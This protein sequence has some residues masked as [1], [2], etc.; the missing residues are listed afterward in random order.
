M[1]GRL[2]LTFYISRP[3]PSS[4]F[5]ESELDRL[6]SLLGVLRHHA[7]AVREAVGE[8]WSSL[9]VIQRSRTAALVEELSRS[10]EAEQRIGDRSRDQ[11]RIEGSAG[12][13]RRRIEASSPAL[14][15]VVAV[16]CC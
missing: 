1:C 3:F 16:R 15:V 7:A 2:R 9:K 11:A 6:S 8:K 4:R 10:D 12:S 5:G 13:M 14:S